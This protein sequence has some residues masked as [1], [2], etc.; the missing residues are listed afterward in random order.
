MKI[1][2]LQMS[3]YANTTLFTS[4]SRIRPFFLVVFNGN[5]LK[6]LHTASIKDM[7]EDKWFANV[8]LCQHNNF[9][10]NFKD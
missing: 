10:L 3:D 7:N 8:R 4:A 9:H 2:G 1:N 6:D 5:H